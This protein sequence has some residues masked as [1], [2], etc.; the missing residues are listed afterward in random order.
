MLIRCQQAAAAAMRDSNQLI[1]KTGLLLFFTITHT[2]V[3]EAT[4]GQYIGLSHSTPS[5][6]P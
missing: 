1:D 2:S 4:I 5:V 6:P 3:W